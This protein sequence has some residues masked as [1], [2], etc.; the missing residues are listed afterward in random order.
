MDLYQYFNL[1]YPI[2]N[3]DYEC[4]LSKCKPKFFAKGEGIISPGQVQ[5]ELYF[6]QKGEQMSYFEAENKI[7]VIAFTY[8]PYPCAIPDS[9]SFQKPSEYY[10]S[11]LSDSEMLSISHL[12]LQEVFNQSQQI[13]RLF[14]ILNE[15]LL[16]GVLKRHA[17]L[18]SL[19]MQERYVAFCK[20]SPH[21]LHTVPHKY[22]A[23]Y[24][25][26]DPTNFSK[27]FNSVNF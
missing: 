3:K 26:I 17:E 16:G 9:F 23:S 20:R 19:S 15:A 14:R 5:K 24:L 18:H 2:S 7:H 10:L 25:G 27:L 4:L 6:V 13:E 21:L 8:P 22:L 12:S 11:C 1:F